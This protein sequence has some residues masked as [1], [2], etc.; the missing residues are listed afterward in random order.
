MQTVG[1]YTDAKTL[2][3]KPAYFERLQRELGLNLVIVGFSGELPGSVLAESPFKEQPPT[4]ESINTV[5]ARHLDGT[6]CSDA[7]ELVQRSVGPHVGQGGDDK[8]LQRAIDQA[9]RTGL[10][11]WLLAGAWTANDYRTL[12]FCPNDA[13]VNKWYSPILRLST[14]LRGWILHTP[15]IR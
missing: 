2:L 1:L 5:L 11:V 6:L 3:Q 8:E 7:P 14:A 9:H 4:V 15:V 12:M 13:Q 10:Q